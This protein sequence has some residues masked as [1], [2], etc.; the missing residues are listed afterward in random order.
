M[1]DLEFQDIISIMT[2]FLY[3]LKTDRE[4]YNHIWIH[5]SDEF[6]VEL[7]KALGIIRILN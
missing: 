6:G 4:N 1:G 7:Y 2:V 3:H 5:C